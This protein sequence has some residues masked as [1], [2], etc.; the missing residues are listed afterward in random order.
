MPA[1]PETLIDKVI[2]WTPTGNCFRGK[3]AT[4]YLFPI[5]IT[6]SAVV[7]AVFWF[8]LFSVLNLYLDRPA[9]DGM[10]LAVIETLICT[11]FCAFIW[12][13]WLRKRWAKKSILTSNDVYLLIAYGKEVLQAFGKKANWSI[14]QRHD[15]P[16]VS[17]QLVDKV[18]QAPRFHSR[19]RNSDVIGGIL[20]AM[21]QEGGWEVLPKEAWSFFNE[22]PFAFRAF[23]SQYH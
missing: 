6:L 4:R 2:A 18:S 1:L 12:R 7:M 14:I 17:V 19:V 13:G 23:Y 3:L 22:Y 5:L 10:T 16:T 20:C 15:H 9:G 21:Y 8:G 11:P